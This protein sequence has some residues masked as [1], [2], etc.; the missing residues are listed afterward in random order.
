MSVDP[1][2]LEGRTFEGGSTTL[3]PWL[4]YLWSKA[5]APGTGAAADETGWAAP[6]S[7]GVAI[8]REA[9]SLSTIEETLR[10]G[11]WSD[12][13]VFLGGHRFSFARPIRVGETYRAQAS[14]TN[15]SH[16]TGGQGSFHVV[17][18]TYDVTTEDGEPAY[19]LETDLIVRDDE[20]DA[21]DDGD[22]G[23][24]FA[25]DESSPSSGDEAESHRSEADGSTNLNECSVGETIARRVF[26][27][28]PSSM[29]LLSAVLRDP[30]PIHFDP[31]YTE[32]CGYPGRV[33]QGPI[34]AEYLAQTALEIADSSAD[35]R[36]L[37]VR[38]ESFVFE[39]DT[40][41]VT[42]TLSAVDHETSAVE[43]D[44]AAHTGDGSVA[45]TGSAVVSVETDRF[46]PAT[47]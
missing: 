22:E 46:A 20:G 2:Q 5:T 33:N 41:T 4:A 11:D 34:N 16:I 14:V 31:A 18:I 24:G 10:G 42:A 15:V 44:L 47:D 19:E 23:T 35:L 21:S 30:N 43:L 1:A 32:R 28:D 29:Q 36:T 8:A 17:T 45:V 3:E 39:T 12:L 37:D 40:V 27:V 26:D 13:S 38:Y 6:P 9:T 25:A 7:T